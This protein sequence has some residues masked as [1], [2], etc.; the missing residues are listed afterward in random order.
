MCHHHIWCPASSTKQATS[1]VWRGRDRPKRKSR[2]LSA[3]GV[4]T[5]SAGWSILTPVCFVDCSLFADCVGWSYFSVSHTVENQCTSIRRA[6]S[7]GQKQTFRSSLSSVQVQFHWFSAV[8]LVLTCW[9]FPKIP[10]MWVLPLITELFETQVWPI[11]WESQLL[12]KGPQNLLGT[13]FRL[14]FG[15]KILFVTLFWKQF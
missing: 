3:A 9:L 13:L 5:C 6:P 8:L 12:R 14:C 2:R 7:S 4:S 15:S 10:V 1:W 11:S